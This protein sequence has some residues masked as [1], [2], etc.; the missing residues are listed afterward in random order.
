MNHDLEQC[1]TTFAASEILLFKFSPRMSPASTPIHSFSSSLSL[2]QNE[3]PLGPKFRGSPSPSLSLS[4]SLPPSLSPSLSLSL[5][6]AVCWGE[7][8]AGH[9]S[10]GKHSDQG[11]E[12]E[13]G[14]Q[15]ITQP[16]LARPQQQQQAPRRF[17]THFGTQ[18]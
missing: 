13:R 12:E 4:H 9:N 17:W 11:A 2:L 3:I 7:Q 15:P 18:G 8:D 1:L 6:V 16:G 14:R 5:S 10:S